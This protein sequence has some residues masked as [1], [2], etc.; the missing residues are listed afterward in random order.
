MV[1]ARVFACCLQNVVCVHVT[2]IVF[3]SVVRTFS[4]IV[5]RFVLSSKGEA[6]SSTISFEFGRHLSLTSLPSGR[7]TP[8]LYPH[9]AY[10]S[11]RKFIRDI[12]L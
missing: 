9:R 10:D 8:L 7:A 2:Y 5:L 12:H 4:C 11:G 6:Q 1:C 3:A